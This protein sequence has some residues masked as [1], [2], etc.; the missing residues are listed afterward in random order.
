MADEVASHNVEHLAICARFVDAENNTR[1]EFLTFVKLERTTDSYVAEQVMKFL[2]SVGLHLC[3]QS[4][5]GASS[6]SSECIGRQARIKLKS[7]LAVYIHCSCHQLNLVI[8]HSC[9]LPEV[10][11][12]LDWLCQVLK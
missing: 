1:E 4:Y 11:N 9:A 12:V 5:D 2:N 7:P 3:G 6:R 8:S 10:H